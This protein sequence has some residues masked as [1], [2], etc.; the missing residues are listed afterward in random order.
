MDVKLI[1][2]DVDMLMS[3][4][5]Y[6]LL[7]K[8][9]KPGEWEFEWTSVALLPHKSVFRILAKHSFPEHKEGATTGFS[10]GFRYSLQV[11]IHS[12]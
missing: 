3:L 7:Q 11:Y 9:L 2:L 10:M 4:K 12:V 5:K 1:S 6:V 8:D